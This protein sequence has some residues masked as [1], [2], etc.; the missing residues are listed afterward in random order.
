MLL[1]I[2][3]RLDPTESRLAGGVHTLCP[4]PASA[5]GPNLTSS[6]ALVTL[7]STANMFVPRAD[8]AIRAKCGWIFDAG[9][10]V[11]TL[12]V[13]RTLGRIDTKG[14]SAYCA[15]SAS[16]KLSAVAPLA[17]LT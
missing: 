15:A 5:P 7:G 14:S 17:S 9:H 6:R 16:L 13:L 11:W 8:P 1:I 10:G 3:L 4:S 12:L 2:L